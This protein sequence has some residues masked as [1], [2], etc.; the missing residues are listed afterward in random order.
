MYEYEEEW[1]EEEEETVERETLACNLV[2]DE[3]RCKHTCSEAIVY[4]SFDRSYVEG[5]E[6][7]EK[8]PIS[9]ESLSQLV[10][11]AKKQYVPYT[12]DTRYGRIYV[13]ENTIGVIAK[14]VGIC[15]EL[16]SNAGYD[17]DF[18]YTVMSDEAAVCIPSSV[19]SKYRESIHPEYPSPDDIARN[20][21]LK[22]ALAW[23][24]PYVFT[25]ENVEPISDRY[26]SFK[27]I[28]I[29]DDLRVGYNPVWLRAEVAKSAIGL[30]SM[31]EIVEELIHTT[32]H[33]E[34]HAT[35]FV[36]EGVLKGG[37][38]GGLASIFGIPVPW[39]A[40]ASAEQTA[41]E[42]IRAIHEIT[43]EIRNH[44]TKFVEHYLEEMD[45]EELQKIRSALEKYS[46]KITFGGSED[47]DAMREGEELLLSI[48]I[49]WEYLE[50]LGFEC[51][52]TPAE[53]ERAR[54]EFEYEQLVR[55][56]EDTGVEI[57]LHDFSLGFFSLS[58]PALVVPIPGLYWD[59]VE[60]ELP[61]EW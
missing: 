59:Y 47:V 46:D 16:L 61:E 14:E 2:C 10:E 53:C 31:S 52:G 22:V 32:V 33:E 12:I 56:F 57:E 35:E 9:Y 42:V 7:S 60:N 17:E 43:P 8:E 54:A 41:E 51:D 45:K 24:Y 23:R 5:I 44:I 19:L 34:V 37:W 20:P 36:N 27:G 21:V 30:T 25:I 11:W 29:D 28:F 58:S 6:I 40:E 1:Y 18:A 55:W 50:E 26:G 13:D 4:E 3:G 39:G 49:D 38:D 48:H 15:R